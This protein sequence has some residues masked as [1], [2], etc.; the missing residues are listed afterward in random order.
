MKKKLIIISILGGLLLLIG[1]FFL[2]RIS[3]K[4]KLP[5]PKSNFPTDSQEF[6]ELKTELNLVKSKLKQ[7]N[8]NQ[9]SQLE[10]RLSSIENKIKILA[11]QD[12]PTIQELEKEIKEIKEKSENDKSRDDPEPIPSDKKEEKV[13]LHANEEIKGF[14]LFSNWLTT[15]KEDIKVFLI[16][17]NHPRIKELLGQGKLQKDKKFTIRYGKVDK[18]SDS[19]ITY[20]FN[21]DNQDLEIMET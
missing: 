19:E 17:K 2:G 1:A 5:E 16:S 9:K 18:T 11:N 14:C 7:S 15:N 4:D 13:F 3:V 6:Q 20:T 8:S 10:N 21:E 12:K